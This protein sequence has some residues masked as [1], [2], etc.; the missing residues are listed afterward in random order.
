M[1]YFEHQITITPSAKKRKEGRPGTIAEFLLLGINNRERLTPIQEAQRE[2]ERMR[3]TSTD[4][5]AIRQA[6]EKVRDLK[7]RTLFGATIS[8]VFTPGTQK[9]DD[10]N[11]KH[12]GIVCIDIDGKD[13]PE[14]TPGEIMEQLR[15]MDCVLYASRSATGTG[16]FAFI[17]ISEPDRHTEHCLALSRLFADMGITLDESCKDITR[18]RYMSYDTEAFC[19][20]EAVTFRGLMKDPKERRATTGNLFDPSTPHSTRNNATSTR[21]D[22][23]ST[24][25]EST[26]RRV[27]LCVDEIEQRHIDLCP[28]NAEWQNMAFSFSALGEEG[29]TLFARVAEQHTGENRATPTQNNWIFDRALKENR[30][31]SIATFLNACM[32]YG[33]NGKEL[34]QAQEMQ[35]FLNAVEESEQQEQGQPSATMTMEEW[36]KKYPGVM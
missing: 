29:R 4:E 1:K 6:H 21:I 18:L 25:Y 19:R 16:V 24:E 23:N 26:I 35:E 33:I 9:A 34:L 27:K 30:N 28:T 3:D 22:P 31:I 8:G 2:Y 20:P 32:Q 11:F 36:Q 13:N 10:H 12:S 5:E 17:P 7:A 15:K 14:K